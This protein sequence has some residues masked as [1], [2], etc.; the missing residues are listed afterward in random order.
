MC[1]GCSLLTRARV[2]GAPM[3]AK[4]IEKRNQTGNGSV[5]PI[6]YGMKTQQNKPA[7]YHAKHTLCGDLSKRFHFLKYHKSLEERTCDLVGKTGACLKIR[8]EQSRAG[9]IPPSAPVISI[10][11]CCF[12]A[13]NKTALLLVRLVSRK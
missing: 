6:N 2:F 8:W 10:M 5:V 9:L 13:N 12:R 1:K 7:A 4:L 3:S 11:T